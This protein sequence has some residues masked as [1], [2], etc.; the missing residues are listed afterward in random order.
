MR[1]DKIMTT[2]RKIHS[3]TNDG[4]T[5]SEAL[6]TITIVGILSSIALPNYLNQVN[7]SRQ[8]EATSTIAQIQTT[9]AAYADEFGVLPTSWADLNDTSAVMTDDGPATK[10][11]FEE[12]I[13]LAGGYYDVKIDNDNDNLFT[14]TATRDDEPN[15]NII[16][17]MNLTNG[18]SGINQ[19]TKAAAAS[20]PN[21]G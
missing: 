16:A 15:L 7:R 18:A 12:A 14:I 21:C 17:C 3:A 6:V 2:P 1:N 13:T 9:I 11:N 20:A 8:N 10:D 5:L 19:G 4:F